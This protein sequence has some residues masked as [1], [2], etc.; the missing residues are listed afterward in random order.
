V[1]TLFINFYAAKGDE[2]VSYIKSLD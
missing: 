2:Q 1:V